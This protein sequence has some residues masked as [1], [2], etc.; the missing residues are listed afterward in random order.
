MLSSVEPLLDSLEPLQRRHVDR[1]DHRTHQHHVLE[2]MIGSHL[3]VEQV[4]QVARLG[5]NGGFH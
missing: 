3:R 4:L 2:V 5:I 1:I